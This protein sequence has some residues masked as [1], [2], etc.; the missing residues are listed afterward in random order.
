MRNNITTP[1]ALLRFVMAKI[2][3]RII[4]DQGRL[5]YFAY[6]TAYD[7]SLFS[8]TPICGSLLL[9]LRLE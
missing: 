9:F 1:P 8:S 2:S 4:V 6:D 7:A 3:W 5:Y